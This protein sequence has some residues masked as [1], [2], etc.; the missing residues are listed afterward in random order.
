MVRNGPSMPIDLHHKPAESG[1]HT[2][3]RRV[4]PFRTHGFKTRTKQLRSLRIPDRL[5]KDF[6]VKRMNA[7]AFLDKFRER[8]FSF[9]VDLARHPFGVFRPGRLHLIDKAFCCGLPHPQPAPVRTVADQKHMPD[10]V[11]LMQGHRISRYSVIAHQI[12]CRAFPRRNAG[13]RA[14]STLCAG[15]NHS[16]ICPPNP[17][18]PPL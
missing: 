8:A 2:V 7:H 9:H 1:S 12:I 10:Y 5:H 14:A 15:G 11:I 18:P 16:A 3:S 13:S 4:H 6:A 17:A